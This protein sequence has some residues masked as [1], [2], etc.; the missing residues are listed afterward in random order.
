MKN[1]SAKGFSLIELLIVMTIAATLMSIAVPTYYKY[2][3]NSNLRETA[4]DISGDIQLYKQRAVAEN[5]RYR[6]IFDV[7][8][9]R[10]TVQK[11]TT[12]GWVAVVTNKA[13]YRSDYP[14]KI[15]GSTTFT[16]NT[17]TFQT[18]GT[19]NAGKLIIRH[20]KRHSEAD[21]ITSMMGR[22]RIEYRLQ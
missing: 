6:M 2:R 5:V 1:K 7:D 18:R 8:N 21:I 19:T 16:S 14:I 10:Y 3:D 22:V 11:Q 17:I 4:R 20:E 13:I 15:Y 9:N 12:S